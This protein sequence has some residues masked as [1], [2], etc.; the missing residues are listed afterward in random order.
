MG[1]V[2]WHPDQGKLFHFLIRAERTGNCS[3]LR[4]ELL[5]KLCLTPISLNTHL[6]LAA[7]SCPGTAGAR[8]E[9]VRA[10]GCSWVTS[11]EAQSIRY[12][13]C[14]GA[15]WHQSG[16]E[17]L[18][19]ALPAASRASAPHS[20]QHQEGTALYEKLVYQPK[21]HRSFWTCVR[22][23]RG[24]VF[25]QQHSGQIWA[26]P[27]GLLLSSHQDTQQASPLLDKYVSPTPFLS[28]QAWR[29]L[30]IFSPKWEVIT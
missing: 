11:T 25:S 16:Q 7:E 4:G 20:H 2:R 28:S 24:R 26:Q 19:A 17:Q 30:L 15:A 14:H 29:M 3:S 8:R 13:C 5:R 10:G 27:L 9:P 1:T 18:E 21:F 6:Q 23:W 22:A 12:K